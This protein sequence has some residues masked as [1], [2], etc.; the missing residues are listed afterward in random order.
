MTELV[1]SST[2]HHQHSTMHNVPIDWV[3][4]GY[5]CTLCNGKCH[6]SCS[7]MKPQTLPLWD[8]ALL[9]SLSTPNIILNR[10]ACMMVGGETALPHNPPFEIHSLVLHR[11]IVASLLLRQQ[12]RTPSQQ[13]DPAYQC[14][15]TICIPCTSRCTPQK[16]PRQP[17]LLYRRNH[18]TSP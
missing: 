7:E 14:Q 12:R 2:Y 13:I 8:L 15:E 5:V 6:S 11:P 3:F 4:A 18:S 17:N 1:S 16:H 10:V 9:D